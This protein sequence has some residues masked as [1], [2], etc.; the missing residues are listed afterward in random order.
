[1][2]RCTRLAPGACGLRP[3][4]VLHVSIS[5]FRNLGAARADRMGDDNT[6]SR[7]QFSRR[8]APHEV[9]LGSADVGESRS[10][11]GQLLQPAGPFRRPRARGVGG[12]AP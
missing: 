10:D 11:C 12:D 5:P 3:C 4:A 8:G 6:P 9:L 1:V 2:G 7:G